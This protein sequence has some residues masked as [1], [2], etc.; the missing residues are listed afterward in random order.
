MHT[1]LRMPIQ[2]FIF[3]PQHQAFP[4][5]WGLSFNSLTL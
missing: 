5:E 2:K 3:F 4:T 1:Y